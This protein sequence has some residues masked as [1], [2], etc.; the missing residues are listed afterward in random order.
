MEQ[1]V[2]GQELRIHSRNENNKHEVLT[3]W[4]HIDIYESVF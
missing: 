1:E 2:E 4:G 3:R